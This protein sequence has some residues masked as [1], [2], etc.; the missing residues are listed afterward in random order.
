MSDADESWYDSDD[1]PP[2]EIAVGFETARGERQSHFA[3]I[4][5]RAV[6][7]D[8]EGTLRLPS[9]EDA[10]EFVCEC[11][12]YDPSIEGAWAARVSVRIRDL[13]GFRMLQYASYDELHVYDCID[14][15]HA[16]VA[17][18][19]MRFV[20]CINLGAIDALDRPIDDL[21]IE[22]CI[23][24]RIVTGVSRVRA[25][26]VHKVPQTACVEGDAFKELENLHLTQR[27]AAI[28]RVPPNS[29]QS[30]RAR[31]AYVATRKLM[32]AP[33]EADRV[34]ATLVW[35][36]KVG[37]DDVSGLAHRDALTKLLEFL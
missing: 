13:D 21:A 37:G 30:H 3:H 34:Q 24:L 10:V 7:I 17:V 26:Y 20:G 33:C 14:L 11:N 31:E 29:I 22:Y 32:W 27:I 35:R 2:I 6:R 15:W 9:R 5:R 19:R 28:P 8:E 36:N 1:D 25:L 12:G 18:P 16:I 23:R 4:Y